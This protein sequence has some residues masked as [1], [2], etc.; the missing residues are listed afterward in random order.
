M[1]PRDLI[2][3][4][5]DV[6]V[7][8]FQAPG[9]DA[10]VTADG[11]KMWFRVSIGLCFADITIPIADFRKA[12]DFISKFD[13]ATLKPDGSSAG[14]MLETYSVEVIN[15]VGSFRKGKI[16]YRKTPAIV[17]IASLN[18]RRNHDIT[19]RLSLFKKIVRWYNSDI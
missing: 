1:K 3:S 17:H 2:Q 12:V 7:A 18:N 16:V 8:V 14:R 6:N 9:F 11:E 4:N 10:R 13:V 19:F 15:C 5:W